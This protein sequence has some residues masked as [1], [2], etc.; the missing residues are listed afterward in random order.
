M[1]TVVRPRILDPSNDIFLSRC[2]TSEVSAAPSKH[3]SYSHSLDPSEEQAELG[4]TDCSGS[5]KVS[6][7]D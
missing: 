4:A 7:D 2:L 6:A 5:S 1:N 3:S